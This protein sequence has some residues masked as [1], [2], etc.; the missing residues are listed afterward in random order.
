MCLV[1]DK[2]KFCTCISKNYETLKHYWLLYRH[3]KDKELF[4]LGSPIMPTSM[5]DANFEINQST[6]LARLNESDAFDVH[7]DLQ[8]NDRLVISINCRSNETEDVFTYS[9][10]YKRK[11][12]CFS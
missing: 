3:D 6:L 2:I 4:V 1:S 8:T 11:M 5:R 10:D 7:L 12:D 9:F